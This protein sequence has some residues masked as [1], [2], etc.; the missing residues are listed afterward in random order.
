MGGKDNSPDCSNPDVLDH[1]RE[2]FRNSFGAATPRIRH[3]KNGAAMGFGALRAA[4]AALGLFSACS[5]A[6]PDIGHRSPAPV[7]N[8]SD[9]F[10]NFE[11][12]PVRPLALATDG[13]YLFVLNTADDRLEIFDAQGDSLRSVGETTVGLRPV[14]IAIRGNE[15][16][17]VNHLSD[18]VSVVDVSNPSRPRVIHTLQVGDEPRGIVV[19]GARSGFCRDGEPR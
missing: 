8:P 11:T 1:L 5:F 4:L 12:E 14:A 15:A 7:S 3:R 6:P 2:I 13:R 17:I 19:A 18:S 16:W 10:T 9:G